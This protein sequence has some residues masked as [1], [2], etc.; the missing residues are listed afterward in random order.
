MEKM[1][2]NQYTKHYIVEALGIL[3]ETK[4]F[5]DITVKEIVEKA[6]VGRATF[7]RNFV[8]KEA[9]LRYQFAEIIKKFHDDKVEKSES[10]EVAYFGIARAMFF[11]KAN[12][13][14]MKNIFRSK[15]E[16][17][18]FNFLD[19]VMRFI[20]EEKINIQNKYIHFGY[21]GAVYN[22]SRQWI[23]N[24]CE[25]SVEEVADALFMLVTA[26]DRCINEETKLALIS[27]AENEV[28]KICGQNH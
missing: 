14:F 15:V 8:D 1:T 13:K 26:G 24:D 21:S 7:Y 25:G 19:D 23:L 27:E 17:L 28:Q 4:N 6:G 5:S 12:K 10:K 16:Y 18:Y 3:L 11:L 9:V 2:Y 20:I 22:I